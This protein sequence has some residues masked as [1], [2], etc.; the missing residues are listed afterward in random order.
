ME[1]KYLPAQTA[2]VWIYNDHFASPTFFDE[3]QAI[4]WY[5]NMQAYFAGCKGCTPWNK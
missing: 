3:E 1:L 5:A 2:W 4:K